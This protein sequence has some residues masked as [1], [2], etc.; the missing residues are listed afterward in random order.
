MKLKKKVLR[1]L[2][3]WNSELRTESSLSDTFLWPQMVGFFLLCAP[4]KIS[5]ERALPLIV[6]MEQAFKRYVTYNSN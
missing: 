2:E 6:S 3:F 4:F 5:S 1:L